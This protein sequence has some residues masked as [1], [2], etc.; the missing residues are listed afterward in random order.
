MTPAKV[1]EATATYRNLFDWLGVEK[2]DYPHDKILDTLGHGLGHCYGMLAK[3]EE[4]VREDRMDKA[5]RW[6]GF[7]QGVIWAQGVYPLES[8]KNHNRPD[9]EGMFEPGWLKRDTEKAVVRVREM[10][11]Q[12]RRNTRP[13]TFQF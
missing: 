5:F 11:A 10:E 13:V 4:F 8:L 1:L 6:L 2:I 9:D 7:I 3:I 12:R